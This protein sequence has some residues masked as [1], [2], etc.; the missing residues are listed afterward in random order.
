M[1][2]T[3]TTRVEKEVLRDMDKIA[4]DKH[5]DRSTLLRNLIHIGLKEEKKER[6]LTQ[7]KH[8]KISMG[9]AKE[10][11]GI[12]TVDF[13][14]LLKREGIYLNYGKAQLEEDLKGLM[15]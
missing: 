6:V 11:L 12:D 14:E 4:K 10:E 1:A 2:V 3:V 9:K 7:Y 8:G 13:I 15:S 5:M